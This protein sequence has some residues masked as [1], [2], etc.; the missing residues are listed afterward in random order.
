M[1]SLKTE[2]KN[3]LAIGAHPDDIEFG[4][5]GSLAHYA[6]IGVSIIAI[7]LTEGKAG[8]HE[9]VNRVAETRTALAHLGITQVINFDFDDTRLGMQ[10][11]A[12][13][14]A[15]E[16]AIYGHIHLAEGVSRVYT[17]CRSD[18]HQDHRIVYDASIVACRMARQILCYETPS[19]WASFAPHVY[20]EI[21]QDNMDKKIVA[22]QAHN[23]QLHRN[24]MQ[25]DQVRAVA[26][27]R[28]QQVGCEMSEAFSIHKMVL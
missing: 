4:C 8:C 12:V 24:Y 14:K 5:G 19:T 6:D 17:M 28:G 20:A 25:P 11:D 9:S 2:L 13:I 23:S 15:L 3:I 27:F 26:R 1:L 16:D 22:L 21:S 7:V 18:R 10:L